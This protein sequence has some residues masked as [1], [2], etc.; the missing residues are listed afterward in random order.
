M[1]ARRKTAP[2]QLKFDQKLVLQQWIF[3]LLEAQDIYD[4]CDE[5]FRHPDTV[6]FAQT[7]KDLEARLKPENPKLILNSFII[8]GTSFRQIS[9]WDKLKTEAD[10]AT[11]HVLLQKD[12][13][14][15]YIGKLFDG[16]VAGN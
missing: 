13:P 16:I 3:S 9:W 4:L 10:F 6:E 11:A 8:S 14:E 2:P 1:P 7:I 5:E 12:E 15:T